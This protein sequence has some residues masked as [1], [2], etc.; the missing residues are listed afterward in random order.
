MLPS[1]DIAGPFRLT[2]QKITEVV[3]GISPGNYTLGRVREDR[4]QG[5]YVGRAD[6]D[7]AKRLH[8]WAKH[9]HRYGA[10]V[11]TYALTARA[12]FDKECEDFHDFGGTEG[13]DNPGHPELPAKTD[14]LCPRC[15][16]YR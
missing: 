16:Y 13:L 14:W 12:A 4:F 6:E 15:D 3:T 2:R 8:V 7:V 9:D 5:L 1:T 11:F 10:F